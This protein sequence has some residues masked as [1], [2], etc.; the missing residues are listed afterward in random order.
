MTACDRS[1][2]T[3][4]ILLLTAWATVFLGKCAFGSDNSRLA[5]PVVSLNLERAVAIDGPV[6]GNNLDEVGNAMMN[7]AKQSTEQIDIAINSPGGSVVTGFLFVNTM[8]AVKAKGVRLRCFVNGIAASMAFQI[9][10][11]CDERYALSRSFLLWHRVRIQIG[12]GMFGGGAIITAPIATGMARSLQ[13]IDNVILSEL[14][15]TVG[16]ELSEADLLYHFEQETLHIGM[17]LHAIAPNFLTI[18]RSIPGLIEAFSE[19]KVVKTKQ[20]RGLF[21][22]TGTMFAPGEIVYIYGTGN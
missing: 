4:L 8:E 5:A 10:T 19:K 9:L 1:I 20:S 12:G 11:H 6:Y 2:N 7:F 18:A 3:I 14:K 13:D 21:D 15:T 22:S 17:N 16:Q